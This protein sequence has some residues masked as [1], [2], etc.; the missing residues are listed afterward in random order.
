DAFQ[1]LLSIGAGT[2][3]IYLLRWFWW[4][5]NAWSE[6]AAMISSFVVAV[7][8]LI[9]RRAGMG[10]SDSTALLASIAVTT[11]VWVTVTLLTPPTDEATLRKFYEATRPAGP[12]W[13]AVRRRA[14]LPPS[15]DSIPQM[16]LGWTAG[17]AFVYAGLF[18]TGNLLYGK[19]LE[20]A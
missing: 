1:L 6:I 7:V 11:V 20:A 17:V 3:L 12:G 18:G 13:A 15:G 9:A 5:I 2:G 10:L 8:L 16:L 19:S 4:R 14:A